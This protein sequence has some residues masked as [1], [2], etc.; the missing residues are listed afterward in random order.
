MRKFVVH[1]AK[2]ILLT[3]PTTA[4]SFSNNP[5]RL[6]HSAAYTRIL[7]R[8][9]SSSPMASDYSTPPLTADSLNPKVLKCEY[10]VRGEIVSLAQKLQQ[11][12]QANPGS[13]PFEE[14]LYCNIGNPQSLGQ[15]PITF[16]RE[17]LALCDHPTILD[18]SETQGLFSAD[19]IE[20]AWQIL[21]QIPGRATGAYSH[22]QGVKGLRDT[23]AA[24]IEARDG[25]PAIQMIFF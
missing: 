6:I 23:I 2:T 22:S 25:F 14:I 12:L 4:S 11:D 15:Q 9:L 18:K 21:D 13:H 10:A 19:S 5:H 8:F 7:N 1:K 20:R 16:F 24:G 17:V 3:K